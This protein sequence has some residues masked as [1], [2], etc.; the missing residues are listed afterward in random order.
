ML[1]RKDNSVH[2]DLQK[3]YKRFCLEPMTGKGQ[4]ESEEKASKEKGDRHFAFTEKLSIT[5][6]PSLS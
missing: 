5:C 3:S 2:P 6:C 1:F 4:P